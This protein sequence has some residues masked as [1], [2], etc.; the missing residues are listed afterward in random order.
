MQE[1]PARQGPTPKGW[2]G[3]TGS[4]ETAGQASIRPGLQEG[5]RLGGVGGV[6][7]G[8]CPELPAFLDF[9][10]TGAP[11][12]HAEVSTLKRPGYASVRSP[13]EMFSLF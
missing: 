13:F 5:Q 8:V 6:G 7:G 3:A 12:L 1:V 4:L 11:R 2:A 9:T 10:R